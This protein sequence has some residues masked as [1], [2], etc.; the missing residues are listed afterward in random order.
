MAKKRKAK[1]KKVKT[2]RKVRRVK[3]RARAKRVAVTKAPTTVQSAYTLCVAGGIIVLI[4]GVLA[5]FFSSVFALT[6]IAGTLI[7]HIISLICGAVLLITASSIKKSPKSAAIITLLFGVIALIFPPH[8]F[9][10]GPILSLIGSVI[11][12]VRRRLE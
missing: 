10:V 4:A 5:L 3:T 7:D 11:L 12:L 2:R 1:R 9:I 6:Q 8:G